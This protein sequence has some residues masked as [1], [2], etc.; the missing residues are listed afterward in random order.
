LSP[1]RFPCIRVW[2]SLPRFFPWS[3]FVWANSP[4]GKRSA[5][6]YFPDTQNPGLERSKICPIPARGS[7]RRV[8]PQ[9]AVR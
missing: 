4:R 5:I 9:G 3:W 8:L 6:H 1:S 7:L 2:S